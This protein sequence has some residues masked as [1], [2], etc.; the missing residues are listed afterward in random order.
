M[1]FGYLMIG[2]CRENVFGWTR[3]ARSYAG[4]H[5]RGHTSELRG[6]EHWTEV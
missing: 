6:L 2:G 4:A 5:A 3:S 1:Y